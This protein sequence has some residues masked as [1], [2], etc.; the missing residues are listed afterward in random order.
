MKKGT[1]MKA[2]RKECIA[3]GVC[4]GKKIA[5]KTPPPSKTKP[6][7]KTQKKATKCPV[8]K[9]IPGYDLLVGTDINRH[10]IKKLSTSRQN[11]Q[12][13]LIKFAKACSSNKKCK[14]FNTW[15]FI[16]TSGSK[17]KMKKRGD[18]LSLYVKKTSSAPTNTKRVYK[19]K[20][21]QKK[22]T[23][24]YDKKNACWCYD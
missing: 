23:A 19:K 4:K 3:S 24:V 5:K 2:C 18:C 1:K 13:S 14:S 16:K 22:P 11:N 7:T 20:N 12:A 17:K 10:D 15:G 9:P 21:Q 8:Y 6:P